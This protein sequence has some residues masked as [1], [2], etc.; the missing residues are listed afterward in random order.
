[1]PLL[2][3][4]CLPAPE[5][6]LPALAG[7]RHGR[8]NHGGLGQLLLG[9]LQHRQLVKLLTVQTSLA[10]RNPARCVVEAVIA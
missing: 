2:L 3:R 6:R 1:M 4:Q 9:L 7:A 10:G 5:G 8:E